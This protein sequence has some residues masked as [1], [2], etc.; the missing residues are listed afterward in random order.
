V[1]QSLQ[2]FMK[3]TKIRAD[4]KDLNS[5][6]ATIPF[7][8]AIIEISNEQRGRTTKHGCLAVSESAFTDA[9]ARH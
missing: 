4:S 7:E 2:K 9:G 8:S 3:F 1:Q 5:H 6:E